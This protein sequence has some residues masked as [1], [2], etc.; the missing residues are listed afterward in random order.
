[1]TRFWVREKVVKILT[2]I[3]R[4]AF[5]T[6]FGI[7]ITGLI[8]P[9][10]SGKWYSKALTIQKP[11]KRVR[12]AARPLNT[13]YGARYC[14]SSAIKYKGKM[15]TLTNRHCCEAY[16]ND[17]QNESRFV[18][19]HLEKI[20]LVSQSNDICVLTSSS[21]VG[22]KLARRPLKAFERVMVM[23]Y[24]RGGRLTPRFGHIISEGSN[25]CLNYDYGKRCEMAIVSTNLVY[26][27][28]S[29][30]PMVNMNGEVVGLVY[31]GNFL[32]SLA[33]SV[34]LKYIRGALEYVHITTK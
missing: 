21:K 7:G 10:M 8:V 22:L 24:P 6:L 34:Q 17:S 9:H 27:A 5:W 30:S 23:G 2:R 28:N 11:I 1:M 33:I 31:G 4:T 32:S 14:S 18:G 15:Y 12:R 26:P 29:G 3:V 20:L 25:I 19:G 16:K 13:I